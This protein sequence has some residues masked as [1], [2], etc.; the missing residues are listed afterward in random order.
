MQSAAFNLPNPAAGGRNGAVIYGGNCN[1]NFN[2]NYPFAFG[3]RIGIA[4]KLNDQ[5]G[6]ARRRRYLLRHLAEQRVSDLQRARFLQFRG[7]SPWLEFRPACSKMAIRYAPGNRFGN[8]PLVYPDFSPHF[9]FT[10]APGYTPPLSPFISI[11]RNA[12]RLPRITPVERRYPT[13]S[14]TGNG[15]GCFLRRQP[16]G[17][18]DRATLSTYAYN[19]LT[20]A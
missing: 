18:V 5:D 12:G 15:I 6:S 13:R 8:A 11:D 3:P 1:C 19:T 7:I 9:P 20:S 4:Y 16:R 14:G 10:T 2:N 17:V